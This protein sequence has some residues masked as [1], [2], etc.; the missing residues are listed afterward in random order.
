M[1]HGDSDE[2][3]RSGG[4]LVLTALVDCDENEG[5]CGTTFQAIWTDDSLSVEDMAEPPVASIT[6]PEC[7][8]VHVAMEWPGWTFYSEAG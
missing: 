3:A 2:Q 5:G 6:C 1:P 4:P 7:G 8:H